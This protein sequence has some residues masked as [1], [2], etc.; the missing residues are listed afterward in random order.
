MQV[1][2]HDELL[3][4][5]ADYLYRFAYARLKDKHA[6]EDLV[7]ETFLAAVKSANFA[8]KSTQRTWLTGI[9]KHK[10]ID[11]FRREQR[12]VPISDL[13]NDSDISCDDFF[14]EN[15]KW[16]D[17][18]NVWDIPDDALEQKQ[19]LNMLDDSIQKLPENLST[20]FLMREVYG[21][22]NQEICERLNI[23]R[24]NAWILLHRARLQ[25]QKKV[26]GALDHDENRDI[27]FKSYIPPTY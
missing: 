22:E 18:V 3:F 5:H 14:D 23:S 10:I 9:L 16:I 15:G 2:N 24:S 11:I 6:A 12:E 21:Y 27:F 17:G 7:Q 19:F 26:Q 20:I 1:H 8:M 4:Q 25:L 13:I